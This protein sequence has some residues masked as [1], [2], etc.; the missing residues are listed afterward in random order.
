MDP[1]MLLFYVELLPVFLI[2]AYIRCLLLPFLFWRVCCNFV[3]TNRFGRSWLRCITNSYALPIICYSKAHQVSAA[4]PVSVLRSKDGRYLNCL[5]RTVIEIN[6]FHEH[7][8]AEASYT[9]NWKWTKI[10]LGKLC[11][12]YNIE[13]WKNSYNSVIPNYIIDGSW[14]C[15]MHRDFLIFPISSA[16]DSE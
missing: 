11:F 5:V 13:P 4:G 10:Q 9:F 15:R 2:D 1:Y 7:C 8:I 3:L 6:I 14:L 12:F 16:G